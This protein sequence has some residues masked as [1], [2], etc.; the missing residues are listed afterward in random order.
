MLVNLGK[1]SKGV[2]GSCRVVWERGILEYGLDA[3]YPVAPPQNIQ[4]Y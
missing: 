1:S 2:L 4:A 3:D